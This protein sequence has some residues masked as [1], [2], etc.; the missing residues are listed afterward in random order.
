M[1]EEPAGARPN[2]LRVSG[3]ILTETPKRHMSSLPTGTVTFLFT[4]RVD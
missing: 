4:D 1:S 2:G 3:G